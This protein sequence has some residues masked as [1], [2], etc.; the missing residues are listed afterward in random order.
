MQEIKAFYFT[1][2]VMYGRSTRSGCTPM[3]TSWW[4][5]PTS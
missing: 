4:R 2:G 5:L 3:S 1:V